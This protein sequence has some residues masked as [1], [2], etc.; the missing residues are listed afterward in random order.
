MQSPVGRQ[1]I[2]SHAMCALCALRL[3]FSFISVCRFR[4][5]RKAEKGRDALREQLGLPEAVKLLPESDRD[6]QEAAMVA[7]GSSSGYANNR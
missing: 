4:S 6:A 5:A 7:F 1:T 2:S 3:Q